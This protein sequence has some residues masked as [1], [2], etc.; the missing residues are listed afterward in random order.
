MGGATDGLLIQRIAACP[1]RLKSAILM[2]NGDGTPQRRASYAS[3]YR[4]V[5]DDFNRDDTLGIVT[6][7]QTNNQM[8]KPVLSLARGLESYLWTF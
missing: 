2:G 7:S 6:V 1:R 4:T 5:T 3:P 8:R